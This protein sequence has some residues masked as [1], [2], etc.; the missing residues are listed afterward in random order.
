[1]IKLMF[2]LIWWSIVITFFVILF[3][4]LFLLDDNMN[5]P[6]DAGFDW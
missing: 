4:V 5:S 2:Q 1:M 6:V 3:P